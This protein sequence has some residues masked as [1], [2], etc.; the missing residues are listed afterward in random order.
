MSSMF[1]IEMKWYVDSFGMKQWLFFVSSMLISYAYIVYFTILTS[2]P[3][4]SNTLFPV[5]LYCY[6]SQQ[7]PSYFHI[8]FFL[9]MRSTVFNENCPCEHGMWLFTKYGRFTSG[10]PCWREVTPVPQQPLPANSS[11]RRRMPR[12]LSS[13]PAR[14]LIGPILCR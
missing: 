13:I 10:C 5:V 11:S 7:M 12:E 6:C 3:L 4:T 14:T 9:L 1:V 2:S 8:F